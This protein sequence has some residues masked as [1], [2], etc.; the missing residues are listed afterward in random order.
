MTTQKS[1][2]YGPVPS[3]RLGLSLG[4]DFVPFKSCSLD[5]IYCQLGRTTLITTERTPCVPLDPVLDQLKTRISLGLEADYITIGGSGEPTLNSN[6]GSLIRSIKQLTDI[7]VA[8]L[9]NGALFFRPDVRTDAAAAD[10]VLPSLDAA[11]PDTF[12]KINRPHRNITIEKLIDGLV[13]F[14]REYT[15]QIWLEVFLIDAVNTAPDQLAKIADAIKRIRPDK[16]QLNTAVRPTAQSGLK[17]PSLQR[18]QDIAGQ[19]AP[20]AEV[21]ADFLVTHPHYHSLHP[22]NQDILEM[23]KRRPC[24][25]PDITAA[26]G[27]TQQN[28]MREISSL[29]K[30][31]LIRFTENNGVVFYH[32]K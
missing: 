21:I 18:L 11:D 9:T 28:V 7:P 3:R 20:N 1:F 32:A 15:G 13:T 16:V 30:D 25:V 2:L 4:V 24:S 5:C 23:L 12:A 31:D 26:L 6:L 14:R 19:L 8:L 22:A 10:V 17:I 29:L 27:I